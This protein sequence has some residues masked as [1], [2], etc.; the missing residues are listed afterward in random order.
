MCGAVA[1]AIGGDRRGHRLGIGALEHRHDLVVVLRGV[2]I[3]GDLVDALAVDRGHRVPP[4]QFDRLR[5]G[6]G[7]RQAQPSRKSD[8]GNHYSFHNYAPRPVRYVYALYGAAD[9]QSAM[10][11]RSF[12]D[13]FPHALRASDEQTYT[14][15]Q[16]LWICISKT[17]SC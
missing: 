9:C 13:A 7:E 10:T 3:G 12:C 2:E 17:K 5:R 6:L 15:S 8:D 16:L 14:R 1:G 11:A 4:L